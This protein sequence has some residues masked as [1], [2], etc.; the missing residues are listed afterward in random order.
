MRR[1]RQREYLAALHET[2]LGIVR[3][4]DL[5]ALLETLIERAVG[6]AGGNSAFIY[7]PRPGGE[8]IERRYYTSTFPHPAELGAAPRRRDS[9]AR[10]GR[11]QSR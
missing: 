4:L 2:T 8:V 5:E 7:L 9:Q 1:S 3:H 11:Q 10:S 6:L